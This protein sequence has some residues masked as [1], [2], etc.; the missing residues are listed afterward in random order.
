M[1]NKPELEATPNPTDAAQEMLR[2]DVVTLLSHDAFCP[3]ARRI[4]EALALLSVPMRPGQP[5]D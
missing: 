2:D 1:V 5:K 3:L 4:D